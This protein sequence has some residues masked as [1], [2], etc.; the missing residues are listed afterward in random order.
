MLLFFSFVFDYTPG[1]VK[2]QAVFGV[3]TAYFL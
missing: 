3:E 1:C 2:K